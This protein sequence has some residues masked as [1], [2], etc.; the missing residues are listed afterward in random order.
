MERDGGGCVIS[1][2][3][4]NPKRA[5]IKYYADSN[6]S[7]KDDSHTYIVNILGVIFS[8]SIMY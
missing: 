1:A 4:V 7:H 3:I 8:V 2:N 5:L 6:V